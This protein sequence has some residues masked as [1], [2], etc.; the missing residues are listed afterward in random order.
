VRGCKRWRSCSS[1]Q[2]SVAR[3]GRATL[4]PAVCTAFAITPPAR[5]DRR[6]GSPH[7]GQCCFPLGHLAPSRSS[8]ARLPCRRQQGVRRPKATSRKV[9]QADIAGAPPAPRMGVGSRKMSTQVVVQRATVVCGKRSS[10]SERRP[11]I[12]EPRLEASALDG[13]LPPLGDKC[14]CRSP[15]TS[16]LRGV[17]WRELGLVRPAGDGD[18]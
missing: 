10:A 5:R 2:S 16:I 9:S 11:L 1:I 8:S 17:S 14:L 7:V 6:D 3:L 12:G 18:R 4:S 13:D 15:F